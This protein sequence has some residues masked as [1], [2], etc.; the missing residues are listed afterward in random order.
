M[1]LICVLFCYN[2]C[3]DNKTVLLIDCYL[4]T[5]TTTAL[6]TN[7]ITGGIN[8]IDTTGAYVKPGVRGQT[9]VDDTINANICLLVCVILSMK[10]TICH[11]F[12][13]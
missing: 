3:K 8:T 4:I 12:N 9:S 7:D 5:T 13:M 1:I 10:P 11:L 2:Q 6:D